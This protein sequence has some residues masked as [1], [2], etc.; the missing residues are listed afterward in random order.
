MNFFE[1]KVFTTFGEDLKL[2]YCG[3]RFRSISHIYGPYD[4]DRYLI[5]YIKEGRATL[6]TEDG[7]ALTLSKGFFVN[8]PQSLATYR[9]EEGSPWTIKWIMAEGEIIEKYLSFLNI[10]K[11]KPFVE[12]KDG[13]N[14]EML[15]DEMYEKFDKDNL[16]DKIYCISLMHMLFSVLAGELEKPG[17]DNDYVVSA[18]KLIEEN[19]RDPEFNVNTLA[20]K[21]GLHHNYFSILYKKTTGISP[22]KEINQCRLQGACKML[23]FTDK[24]IKEVA[25]ENGFADELYFSRIFKNAFGVS[26]SDYKK[27]KS[28]RI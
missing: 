4:Q 27:N 17:T 5:Y 8:F 14:I 18:K 25:L 7:K 13:R 15:F 28:L 3:K 10:T 2:Y 20:E 19:Y 23:N 21:L 12:L 16:S 22:I 1:E 24:R 11:N 9:C 26:P 6:T